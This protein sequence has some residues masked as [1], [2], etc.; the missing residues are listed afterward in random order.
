L[1]CCLSDNGPQG[2]NI[3]NCPGCRIFILCEIHCYLCPPFFLYNNSVL[4][5]VLLLSSA[6]HKKL[7]KTN[8]FDTHT[9]ASYSN[10]IHTYI[11]SFCCS[12]SGPT[13]SEDGIVLLNKKAQYR[14]HKSCFKLGLIQIYIAKVRTRY[15][16][17]S[18]LFH[19]FLSVSFLQKI[20]SVL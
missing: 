11:H 19:K 20:W 9:K 8:I 3:F 15:D 10:R 14:L 18:D 17:S 2:F 13:Q 16:F 6:F 1:Q 4:A 5:I 7:V 12:V